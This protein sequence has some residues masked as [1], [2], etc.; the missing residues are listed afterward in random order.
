MNLNP[1]KLYL[2]FRLEKN[3]NPSMGFSYGWCRMPLGVISR[4]SFGVI[5][6]KID[7]IAKTGKSRHYRASTPQC[8]PMPRQEIP[9][10]G[11][12]KVKK[13]HPSGMSMRSIAAPRR[14]YYSQ[15]TKFSIFVFEH[16]VFIHR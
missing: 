2:M 10:H 15:Q 7:K 1:R 9:R 12:A 5:L 8:R 6:E 14:S 11:E 16:L 3:P 4:V 13:W